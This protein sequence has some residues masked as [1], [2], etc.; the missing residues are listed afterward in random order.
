YIV[1]SIYESSRRVPVT[2]FISL[3]QFTDVLTLSFF[4]LQL[5]LIARTLWDTPLKFSAPD[6]QYIATSP[7]SK[8][9]IVLLAYLQ[10]N[11]IRA[12]F[13]AISTA[14]SALGLGWSLNLDNVIQNGIV[15]LV[16]G[17]LLVYLIATIGWL[18]G[19][20]KQHLTTPRQQLAVWLIIPV[21]IFGAILLPSIVLFPAQLW[22]DAQ[23]GNFTLG[24]GITLIILLTTSLFTLLSISIQINT[25]RIIQD[26]AIYARIQKLGFMGRIYA[27]DVIRRIKFQAKLSKRVPARLFPENALT[28]RY[29]LLG[30]SY[31]LVSRQAPNTPVG[32]IVEGIIFTT[33]PISLFA[34][35]SYLSIETWFVVAL[36][37]LRSHPSQLTSLFRQTMQNTY[38]RRMIPDKTTTLFISHAILPTLLISVGMCIPI[39]IQQGAPNIPIYF[40]ALGC[41]F[42]LMF[43]LE[44]EHIRLPSRTL[45]TLQYEHIVLVF[46]IAIALAFVATTS[47]WIVAITI[48]ALD[49]LLL[50]GLWNSH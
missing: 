14:L 47:F 42:G 32:M 50:F 1:D 23:L 43:A 29:P 21:F 5:I 37:F 33:I 28:N 4:S 25:T 2:D 3:T 40:I 7:T 36:I 17:F 11:F 39:L 38:L 48:F 49:A 18:F 8:S 6:I 27:S 10:N 44:S 24:N 41:L 31:V 35:T 15:T 16:A 19:I 22:V 12:C 26:S 9:V 13:L 30:L 46:I 45:P 34:T 20:I